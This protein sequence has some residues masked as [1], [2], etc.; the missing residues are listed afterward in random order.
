MTPKALENA[1]SGGQ[2]AFQRD[3][4]PIIRAKWA[5]WGG[6]ACKRPGTRASYASNVCTRASLQEG[7]GYRIPIFRA[8][9]NRGVSDRHSI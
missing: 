2:E 1:D 8:C 9:W 6:L 4:G 3:S 5:I 7:E